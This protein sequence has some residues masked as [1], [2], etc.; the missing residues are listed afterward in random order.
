M[1]KV[2]AFIRKHGLIGR[3]DTVV[4]AV[5]GGPDSLALLHYL[6]GCRDEFRVRLVAASVD[7]G[8]RGEESRKDRDY[9][10]DICEQLS[11][12]FEPITLDVGL[13]K[14]EEGI[15]TQEAA[16]DLRYEALARVM[17]KYNAD[18]LALGHHGD[19]QI[20]TLFMQLVRG[21]T[22]QSATG[23]PVTRTFAGGRII[24]PFLPLTKNEIEAYCEENRITPRYDSSNEDTAYTRNA[25]RHHMLP[26]LKRQN[27]KLHEHIQAYSERSREDE[28]FLGERAEELLEDVE[29]YENGA[30]FFIKSFKRHP[31]ALQRRAFHLILNYLYNDQV[32][33][34]TY[35]HEDLF[36]RLMDGGRVNSSLDFPKGLIITKAYDRV[37]FT[38]VRREQDSAPL[39]E[40][41]PDSHLTLW[42]GAQ[43]SA[44]STSE[45]KDTSLYEFTCDRAHVKFPLIVRTRQ[46]GDRMKPSGM[47]G[48]KKIKDIF[49][50]QKI[51]A[52]ERD[53]WPIVTDSDGVILWIPGLKKGAVELNSD[54]L[55]RLKYNRSGRRS[56]NA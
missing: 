7:H 28:A 6:S 45:V 11:I 10:E 5:S 41:Y 34:I 21:A 42:D 46:Y 51:P 47:K 31:I 9:V 54:S 35:I 13:H 3:E 27:P 40:L 15:G 1:Q 8:L 22:P 16:R 53:R 14:Q 2:A 4:V 17:Q 38:W 48:T 24:R 49:I 12:P 37:T 43:I 52:A 33:D 55:V 56:G 30:G 20:E 23:I 26:F 25:F 39:S 29:F 18:S 19:D 36:L 32:E 44:E 50:D